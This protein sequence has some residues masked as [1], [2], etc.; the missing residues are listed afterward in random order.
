MRAPDVRSRCNTVTDLGIE[1]HH[2]TSF[3]YYYKKINKHTSYKISVKG[4]VNEKPSEMIFQML[5]KCDAGRC[6]GAQAPG[7]GHLRR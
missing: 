1:S 2:I 5:A 6:N 7:P 3:E 4:G